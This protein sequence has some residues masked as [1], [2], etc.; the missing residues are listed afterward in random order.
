M[1]D[2]HRL[3]ERAYRQI[4]AS[5]KPPYDNPELG[6]RLLADLD[7]RAELTI[8]ILTAKPDEL[9]DIIKNDRVTYEHCWAVAEL[10]KGIAYKLGLDRE[11]AET[12]Y[13]AG[14]VHDIGK[15]FNG[16]YNAK[17]EMDGCEKAE[18][19][20]I[21]DI[22]VNARQPLDPLPSAMANAIAN[23]HDRPGNG[24][25]S[26][27]HKKPMVSLYTAILQPADTWHAMA[28]RGVY[29]KR[30]T[31]DEIARHLIEGAKTGLYL[32]AAVKALIE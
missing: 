1:K 5:L 32:P 22:L 7:E 27:P 29:Q 30:F 26:Y 3:C 11:K 14:L 20:I 16:K 4:L 15:L 13:K 10:A 31:E 8:D 19:V 21:G 28:E 6:M 24:Q 2:S 23:H 17:Q 25:I 9:I 18:H 12:V